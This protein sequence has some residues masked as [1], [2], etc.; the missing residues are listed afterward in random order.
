MTRLALLL[1]LLSAPL[2][3]AANP[4]PTSPVRADAAP[5]KVGIIGLDNYQAVDFT[6]H[7]HNP[8]SADDLK[9]LKVVAAYPAG[10]PDIEES[11]R[12]LPKWVEAMKKYGVEIVK[13]PE[14]VIKASDAIIVMSVDGR[15]HLEQLKPVLKAGK[16]VYVG[17]PLAASLADAVEIFRLAAE[18][19]TPI[20]T[21]SQHRFSPGFI[22][23]RNHPEVGEVLGADVYGGCP[24]EPH[25]PDLFW[26]GIHGVETLY[27][28][29]GPGCVSV[30]R[31]S[32]DLADQVTGEWKDGRVGT[33][34]GIRKGAPKY[35][36]TVFGT[37]GVSIAGVYGHG[38]PVKGVAPT[39]DKYMGYEPTATEIAKFFKT[40]TPPVSAEETIEVFAF[41]EAAEESKRLKGTPVKL[42][43]VLAKAKK[44]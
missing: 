22:G 5:I 41:M 2:L 17:R 3:L 9:G 33:Y 24:R 13:S 8:K 23:M 39:N 10:S 11:M 6:Q 19:K 30:T 37:K 7:W 21:C 26:H 38:I 4:Q 35:S 36:A 29:M 32:T 20:F 1:A 44:K 14:D 16:P 28:I 31:T 18:Y 42:E 43:T 12:E 27:T 34:R 15:A 40:K 25:H